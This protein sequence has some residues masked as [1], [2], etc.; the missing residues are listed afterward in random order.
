MDKKFGPERGPIHFE[1]LGLCF[2]QI[3][4][5]REPRRFEYYLSG[6]I[7]QGWEAP[8]D[9]PSRY[10]IARPTYFAIKREAWDRGEACP[11]FAVNQT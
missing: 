11:S 3:V 10:H 5:F 1:K 8:N 4:A 2:Y 6:A 7:V 9:L